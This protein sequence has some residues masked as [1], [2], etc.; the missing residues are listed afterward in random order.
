MK[1]FLI[2]LFTLSSVFSLSACQSFT[3]DTAIAAFDDETYYVQAYSEDLIDPIRQK[4]S[5]S[6]DI[7]SIVHIINQGASTPNGD[8]AYIYEFSNEKDATWFEENRSAYVSSLEEG[9]CVR[10]GS[11]VIF[12]TSSVIDTL[13]E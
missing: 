2:F 11:I 13:S 5:L 7:I 10:F 9:R 6:G 1:R 8:F 12:G 4:M 3:V